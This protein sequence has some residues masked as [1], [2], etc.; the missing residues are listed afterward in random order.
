LLVLELK[1][2]YTRYTN[3]VIATTAFGLRVDSLKQPTNEFYMMGQEATGFGAF[4]FFLFLSI[5][6]VMKVRTVCSET[7]YCLVCMTPFNYWVVITNVLK[8]CSYVK[9][10]TLSPLQRPI[11]E[12]WLL[13]I[14]I[15]YYDSYLAYINALCDKSAGVF[16]KLNI[17]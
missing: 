3:D 1:E 17:N 15:L 12:C 13:K 2:F 9:E 5:P 4:K 16:K 8:I 7:K 11:C 10:N 6:K 14:I